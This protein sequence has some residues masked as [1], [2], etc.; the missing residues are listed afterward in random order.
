MTATRC[1]TARSTSST[2]QRAAA[3]GTDWGNKQEQQR[4]MALR[5]VRQCV[6]VLY[7]HAYDHQSPLFGFT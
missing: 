7:S 2:E 6:R 3:N 1:L 5:K 4:R